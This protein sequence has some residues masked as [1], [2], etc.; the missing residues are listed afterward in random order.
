MF[1]IN[2]GQSV[3]RAEQQFPVC[4]YISTV[5]TVYIAQCIRRKEVI[6]ERTDIRIKFGNSVFG[7][8]PKFSLLVFQ[9][10]LYNIVNQSLFDAV[11]FI[12]QDIVIIFRLTKIKSHTRST[13]PNPSFA[14][15]KDTFNFIAAKLAVRMA[16]PMIIFRIGYQRIRMENAD[17]LTGSHPDHSVP[18]FLKHTNH[19]HAIPSLEEMLKLIFTIG[20]RFG[21]IE[22]AAKCSDPHTVFGVAANSEDIIIG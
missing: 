14:I 1:G 4:S 8:N 12:L 16:E 19:L 20:S 7:R 6:V 17:S 22:S 13:C 15:L 18:V 9:N 5:F 2:D 3:V 21:Q 11:V 10:G